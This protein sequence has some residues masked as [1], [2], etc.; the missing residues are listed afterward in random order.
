VSEGG[1]PRRG[2]GH[3][4]GSPPPRRGDPAGYALVVGSYVLFS[5]T[6][7]LIAWVSMPASLLLVVRYFIA[8]G[9]LLVVFWRRRPLK[10][11]LRPGVW[12]RFIVMAALDASQALAYFYAVRVLGVAVATFL[13]YL[14]PLWVALLAPRFLHVTTE[15]I[16]YLAMPVAFVGLALVLGPSFSDTGSLSA[17]GVAAALLAGLGFAVF[18][19]VIKRQSRE[20]SSVSVVIVMCLLD[21]LFLLP[22]AALQTG[23]GYS[24]SGQDL[25]AVVLIGV[26]TTALAFTMWVDGVARVRVQHSAILGLLSAVASPV[27]AFLLLRQGLSAWTVAGGALILAAG[28]AVVLRGAGE[29][30]LEPPL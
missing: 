19:I 22:V 17:P 8:A 10:G 21:G 25:I 3:E 30:E 18:Q 1:L 2:T 7:V 23:G 11:V 12:Q 29:P 4:P 28:A 15:R 13:Y 16:V 20:V 6:P 26:F 24:L 14:Q 27:F 5:L 9:I